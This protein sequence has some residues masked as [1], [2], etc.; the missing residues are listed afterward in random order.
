MARSPAGNWRL[1]P[2]LASR[3]RRRRDLHRRP[4]QHFLMERIEFW[5]GLAPAAIGKAEIG[6]T[7]HAN[8]A[9]LGD[10]ERTRQH[11]GL[12]LEMRHAAPRPVPVIVRPS[13]PL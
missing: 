11:F 4:L 6:I 7:E 3:R 8:E 9:D 1:M 13:L 10:R 2:I 12:L 5:I